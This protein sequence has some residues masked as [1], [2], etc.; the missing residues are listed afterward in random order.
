MSK[1]RFRAFIDDGPFV[2]LIMLSAL[3]SAGFEIAAV[4]AVWP[5][6]SVSAQANAARPADPRHA[7]SAGQAA[8]RPAFA[9]QLVA[10]LG[11]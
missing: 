8:S 1:F 10:R 9:P 6:A 7:V 5:D 11:R 4:I 3:A 2:L